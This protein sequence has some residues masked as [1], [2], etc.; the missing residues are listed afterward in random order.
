MGK[1]KTKKKGTNE[2]SGKKLKNKVYLKKLAK[3]HVE[4]GQAPGMGQGQG[5]QGLYRL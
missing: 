1:D 3:L 2:K 4:T 5:T